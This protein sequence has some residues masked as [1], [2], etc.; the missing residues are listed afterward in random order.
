MVL[1]IT[2]RVIRA[3]NTSFGLV[4]NSVPILLH[5]VQF[6]IARV[7]AER[8][9]LT[10]GPLVATN[11]VRDIALRDIWIDF[12]GRAL[13]VGLNPH[14]LQQNKNGDHTFRRP[15]SA[16]IAASRMVSNSCRAICPGGGNATIVLAVG[17]KE[18]ISFWI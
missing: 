3:R 7:V 8:P 10:G 18:A 5:L 1:L 6:Q 17:G 2:L 13:G 9:D 11:V 16:P 4:R 14:Q 12:P 15:S